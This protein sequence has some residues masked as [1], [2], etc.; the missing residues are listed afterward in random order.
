MSKSRAENVI[1]KKVRPFPIAAQVA[2]G[3]APVRGNI[4][5]LTPL[6][7]LIEI[8]ANF[9]KVGEK[10]EVTFELPVSHFTVKEGVVVV[11]SYNQFGGDT[12]A[13]GNLVRV[14]EMHFRAVSHANKE[15]ITEF[16][17]MVKAPIS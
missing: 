1:A 6:G 13:G 12:K 8:G 9:M 14:L 3:E 10:Y 5:K 4:I 11:K 17:K 16:L 15:K 7:F 2:G